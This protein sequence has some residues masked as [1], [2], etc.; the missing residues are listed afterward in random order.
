MIDLYYYK[1]PNARKIYVALEEMALPYEAL[2]VDITTGDQ[3]KP[4]P[5]Y[6]LASASDVG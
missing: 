4:E 1:S 3:F 5:D 2:W 6:A